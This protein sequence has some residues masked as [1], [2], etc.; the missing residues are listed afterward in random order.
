MEKEIVVIGF[1]HSHSNEKSY[2]TCHGNKCNECHFRYMCY[3]NK[4]PFIINHKFWGYEFN[5][6]DYPEYVDGVYVDDRGTLV[7]MGCRVN[8]IV[9]HILFGIIQQPTNG[10]TDLLIS[11]V[12]KK[13]KYDT[14]WLNG[15]TTQHGEYVNEVI[16]K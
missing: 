11:Q 14:V 15:W 2:L 4:E 7:H 12:N 8:Y 1:G 16:M 3:T 5:G 9:E 13:N 10:M 6:N